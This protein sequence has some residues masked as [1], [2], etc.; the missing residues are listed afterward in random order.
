MVAFQ[1]WVTRIVLENGRRRLTF[2]IF[3]DATGRVYVRFGLQ[4]DLTIY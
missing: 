1:Q 3:R 2:L 4:T